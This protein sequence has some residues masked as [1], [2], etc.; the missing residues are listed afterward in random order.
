[1][2]NLIQFIVNIYLTGMHVLKTYKSTLT[3]T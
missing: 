1:M 3:E 2:F